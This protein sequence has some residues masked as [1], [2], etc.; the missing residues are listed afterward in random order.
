MSPAHIASSSSRLRS[1]AIGSASAARMRSSREPLMELLRTSR[2][3]MPATAPRSLEQWPSAPGAPP[4]IAC[5][6]TGTGLRCVAPQGS[7]E[8][9]RTDRRSE[10]E[11]SRRAPLIVNAGKVFGELSYART[12]RPTYGHEGLIYHLDDAPDRERPLKRRRITELD[13]ITDDQAG[14]RLHDA[15]FAA[16]RAAFNRS[17]R[18]QVAGAYTNTCREELSR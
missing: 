8:A 16:A 17:R 12:R 9:R 11:S 18:C 5:I 2:P 1:A 6:R 13:A 3:R 15:L 14:I 10:L 4:W 7:L